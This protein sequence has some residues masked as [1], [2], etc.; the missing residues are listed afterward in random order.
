MAVLDVKVLKEMDKEEG[1]RE[2]ERYIPPPYDA[3]HDVIDVAVILRESEFPIFPLTHVP[4]PDEYVI[5]E[6][7][8]PLITVLVGV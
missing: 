5:R 7:E 8:H 2:K 3:V 6:N 4:F 1:T